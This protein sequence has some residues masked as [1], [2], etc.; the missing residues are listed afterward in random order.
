MPNKDE[1]MLED[2]LRNIQFALDSHWEKENDTEPVK[3]ALMLAIAESLYMIVKDLQVP[4][5]LG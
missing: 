3:I 4:K 5:Y 1:L 2:I